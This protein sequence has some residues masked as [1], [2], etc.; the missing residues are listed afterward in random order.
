MTI[1]PTNE[2][3]TRRLMECDQECIDMLLQ[4]KCIIYKVC[5]MYAEG[6]DDMNGLF[7]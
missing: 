1:L 6:N 4:N 5:F 2:G 7:V 3:K